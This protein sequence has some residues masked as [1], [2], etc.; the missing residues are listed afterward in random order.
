[1]EAGSPEDRLLN[2]IKGKYKKKDGTKESVRTEKRAVLADAA[3]R[4]F[5]KNKLFKPAFLQSLN[6]TLI[7]IALLI[8]G[9]LVYSIIIHAQRD[10][11][12]Y[13]IEKGD[14]VSRGDDTA[15]EGK[16]GE[17]DARDFAEYS[18]EIG[19]RNLFSAPVIDTTRQ[20]VP[21][22]FDVTSRFNLVG[23]IAGER[24][25]AIIED[26]ET[27][28]TYYLYKGESFSGVTVEDVGEGSVVLNYSGQEI[29][30]VL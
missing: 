2:L 12:S 14:V 22:S 24:P 5:L 4:A 27:Q 13:V 11:D 7:V 19:N 25:Q 26:K 23:I 6:R 21:V 20:N 10:T 28:K 9:Y 17:D 8:S 3:K 15:L 30:L 16:T 18:Q 29:R 1:M